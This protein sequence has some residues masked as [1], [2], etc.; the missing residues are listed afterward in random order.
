MGTLAGAVVGRGTSSDDYG[1]Y[2]FN[3][4]NGQVNWFS[5]YDG[6][7]HGND[8]ARAIAVGM[9]GSEVI[10]GGHSESY[11]AAVGANNWDYM[12][13]GYDS[14]TGQQMFAQRFDFAHE[15]LESL[16]VDPGGSRLYVGGVSSFD[17]GLPQYAALR[18]NLV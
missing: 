1:T 9:N 7:G 16:S 4:T 12:V 11:G 14:T 6:P 17:N 8:E 18:Y 2:S 3:G 15:A 10:V 13:V 5:R